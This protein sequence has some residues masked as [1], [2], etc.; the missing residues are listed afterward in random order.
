LAE[1]SLIIGG[2]QIKTTTAPNTE[3]EEE[4]VLTFTQ[5]VTTGNIDLQCISK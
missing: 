5:K 4:S 2:I 3:R 1:T